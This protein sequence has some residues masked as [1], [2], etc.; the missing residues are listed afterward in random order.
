[1]ADGMMKQGS[2]WSQLCTPLQHHSSFPR[3]GPSTERING[4]NGQSGVQAAF[5]H[6]A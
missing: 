6:D 3:P 2:E 4:R 1:M 5:S